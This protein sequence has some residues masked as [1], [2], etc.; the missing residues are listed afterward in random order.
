MGSL[1]K[2]AALTALLASNFAAAEVGPRMNVNSTAKVFTCK[3]LITKASLEGVPGATTDNGT[4]TIL[5]FGDSFFA[6]N[7]E[8]EG[9]SYSGRL[10]QPTGDYRANQP[11]PGVTMGKGFGKSAGT[12]VYIGTTVYISWDCR[13]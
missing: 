3:E 7:P 12:Y 1:V 5:D 13:M 2:F 8:L 6:L 9:V 4:V 11:V 10:Y